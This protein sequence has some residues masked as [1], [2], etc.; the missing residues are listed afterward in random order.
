MAKIFSLWFIGVIVFLSVANAHAQ[1]LDISFT[2][3]QITGAP[4]APKHI[5]AIWIKDLNNNY[6]RTL[7]VYADKRKTYLYKWKANSNSDATDAVTGATTSSLKAYS[8]TWNLKDYNYNT[9]P[10]GSYKLCMEM[11]SANKQGPYR[12]I[13]FTVDGGD[14]TIKPDDGQNFN[15]ISLSFKGATTGIETTFLTEKYLKAFPNPSDENLF[16]DIL[17]EQDSET[18]ISIFDLQ[19]RLVSQVKIMLKQGQNRVDLTNEA[20]TLPAGAYLMLV[21]TNHYTL[22]NKFIIK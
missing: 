17:L 12:E 14:Y 6:V 20:I 9:V 8:L 10:A 21:K 22:G 15:S 4:Y 16:A 3:T 1:Q 2:T 18:L 7:L 11:T 13:D 19:N 5:L